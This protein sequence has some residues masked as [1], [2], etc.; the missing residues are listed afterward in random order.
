MAV[1]GSL[2]KTLSDWAKQT[3]PD[4]S[5]E[6]NVVEVLAEDNEIL[7]DMKWME[8]NEPTGHKTIIRSGLPSATW[9][10]LYEG[11]PNAKGE[12]V[13]VRDSIG[14]LEVYSEV[15]KSL[16]DLSGDTNAF[17]FSEDMAFLEG[18]DQQFAEALI[19]GDTATDPEKFMGLAPRYNDLSAYNAE[20]IIVGGGSGSDNTSVWLVTWG[21][22]ATFGI[23]PK[24]QKGGLQF[25]DKGQET[26]FDSNNKKFEGYRSHYK[27]DAGLVVKDW[28]Y[29]VRIPNIDVSDLGGSS[30]ADIV[31][32]MIKALHKLPKKKKGSMV[33]YVNETIETYLD[34]QTKDNTNTN[35][36]Y[37]SDI[38]GQP[39]LMFRG[40]PV[41]RVDSILDTEETVS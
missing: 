24:G 12:T 18:M 23:F 22:N 10:K 4:G 39:I 17:R 28:R 25:E 9:R 15:D 31:S 1:I 2:S 8:S 6:R 27:W 34:L 11:V 5:I 32:L 36:N 40:V 19:Y 20:N 35:L 30:A 33:F 26:L 7:A 16:A 3:L 29:N 41:R 13:P 38:H 14:M 37:G 21:D